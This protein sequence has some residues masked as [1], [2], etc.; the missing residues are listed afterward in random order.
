MN[1]TD[2]LKQL[3]GTNEGVSSVIGVVILTGVV[4][5]SVTTAGAFMIQNF[6]QQNSV[7]PLSNVGFEESRSFITD[8]EKK[9]YDYTR[10]K[11]THE[12]G[13][14]VPTDELRITVD[15]KKAYSLGGSLGASGDAHP[16]DPF[17]DYGGLLGS[18][19]FET[20]DSV[21]I[22]VAMDSDVAAS[23]TLKQ[24]AVV[25]PLI[26]ANS[27]PGPVKL[28]DD[29]DDEITREIRLT[30]GQTVRVIHTSTDTVIAE[31]TISS[32]QKPWDGTDDSDDDGVSD[33]QEGN[34]D[35][36]GDGS[37]SFA[38]GDTDDDGIPDS[39]E[40][41]ETIDTDG[42]GTPDYKD[43][44]SDGDYIP[45]S[46]EYDPD[47]PDAENQD[48][49]GNWH[50]KDF[51]SSPSEAYAEPLSITGNTKSVHER[52]Q[53]T[54]THE[55]TYDGTEEWATGNPRHVPP[56]AIDLTKSLTKAKSGSSH[57]SLSF[58]PKL[59][60]SGPYSKTQS[61]LRYQAPDID[62]QQ[63]ATA[64][65]SAGG[66]SGT[67]DIT[68]QV[69]G[70][71]PKVLNSP[72]SLEEDQQGTFTVQ[73]VDQANKKPPEDEFMPD[74][75]TVDT[76]DHGTIVGSDDKD[77]GSNGKVSFTYEAD[78]DVFDSKNPPST[79]TEISFE[80]DGTTTTKDLTIINDPEIQFSSTPADTTLD[81]GG[82]TTLTVGVENEHQETPG[83]DH[84]LE[85]SIQGDDDSYKGSLNRTSESVSGNDQIKFK[86]SAP[87]RG[88]T[89][90]V[91]YSVDGNEAST[92]IT[93]ND[94]G[95]EIDSVSPSTQT[96]DPGTSKTLSVSVQTE[97]EDTPQQSAS[98]S[99][100][101]SGSGSLNTTTQSVNGEDTVKF[102]YTAP[103]DAASDTITFNLDGTSES[104]TITVR[105]PSLSITSV[106]PSSTTSETDSST[107]IDV[108]VEN[109][110]E[111][112]PHQSA[113]VS[114]SVSGSGSISDSDNSKSAN[115]KDSVTFTYNAPSSETT[116]TVTF[117]L[118][119][120]QKSTSVTVKEPTAF[121][122][123]FGTK[124]WSIEECY[125]GY[126]SCNL[127]DQ[128]DEVTMSIDSPSNTRDG[129]IEASTTL[130]TSGSFEVDYT[131]DADD[132]DR[133]DVAIE[134]ETENT[135]YYYY[136]SL[137]YSSGDPPSG[138]FDSEDI[139]WYSFESGSSDGHFPEGSTVRF[140]FSKHYEYVDGDAS[141][142]LS[143]PENKPDLEVSSVSPSSATLDSGDTKTIDVSVQN[144]NGQ[145]P[146][147]AAW[148]E[149]DVDGS[150]TL[151]SYQKPVEGKDQVSFTYTA[152]D[153]G[154]TDTV[155]FNLDG[156]SKSTTVTVNDLDLNIPSVSASSTTIPADG[157]TD[158]TVNVQNENGNTP[159]QDKSVSASVSGS[160]SIADSDNKKS[161]NG[162][163]TVTFTYNAP[164][165]E[166]DDTVDFTL[167]G[168]TQSVDISSETRSASDITIR[169]R[170]DHHD[171]GWDVLKGNNYYFEVY[172]T[173]QFDDPMS[174][175]VYVESESG[176]F[177]GPGYASLSFGGDSTLSHG[178][179]DAY[180][181]A[182]ITIDGEVQTD[183]ITAGISDTDITDTQT[184]TVEESFWD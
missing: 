155:T 124:D 116:D 147:Q 16:V 27:G 120:S 9:T 57:E 73:V 58:D 12:D 102:K 94:P 82:E 44:D 76:G 159:S 177:G 50:F 183:T 49:D 121:T 42:D 41:D 158:I 131:V 68:V 1:I 90:T 14:P 47:E 30:K 80:A 107:T 56:H 95:L 103:E 29:N 28:V 24:T 162:K 149:A 55:I 182:S 106:S 37:P 113:S 125:D 43:L 87:N 2:R 83:H 172:V 65:V 138:T 23:N 48:D 98:V 64:T 157:S 108:S 5:V 161:V 79:S 22:Y 166:T 168:S 8:G 78:S 86:Y 74:S 142:I 77:P 129:E 173:D 97:F 40:G 101:F 18:G 111:S 165:G 93:V 132:V 134:V 31:H 54:F 126:T 67:T 10:V 11:I 7:Q 135:E 139:E 71:K 153:D 112:T 137:I 52:E 66:S 88:T 81:A 127:D 146:D 3:Y 46:V 75:V 150:G 179:K 128:R 20:G 164:S 110:F 160:G 89:D 17:N 141:L 96:I 33:K 122:K 178:E 123:D 92:T 170:D 39:V 61:T 19:S 104:S 45:D 148:I 34:K 21:T 133:Y 154:T 181:S 105:E 38:T 144:E 145:T 53:I 62:T 13:E 25:H 35:D 118:D 156:T 51:D 171:S 130:E 114:A 72:S 174:V 176:R 91:T 100:S 109:Q 36:S 152:P 140:E 143:D 136:N 32:E 59:S 169:N 117:S 6:E 15:N 4:V 99:T 151:D 167:D 26:N 84:D 119:G 180:Y 60:Q 115:G 63:S 163:N 85:A 175:E 69:N 184:I 70:I